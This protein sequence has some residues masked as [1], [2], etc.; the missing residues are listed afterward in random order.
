MRIRKINGIT[1]GDVLAEAIMNDK[2]NVIIP[3][4][5]ALKEEY[6][7]L[8]ESLGIETVMIEDPY[9]DYE[10]TNTII[11]EDR[12]NQYVEHVRDLMERHIYHS[13]TSFHEFEIIAYELMKEVNQVDSARLIDIKERSS[14]LYDHTVMVTILSLVIAKRLQLDKNKRYNIAIG[15]LLHDLGLRY[16]TVPYTNQNM[17]DHDP[18]AEFE[19]KKHTI[20]GY[21]ALEDENWIP[22]VSRK[23]ILNH[24]ENGEGTGFPMRQKCK[25]IECRII[26]TVDAFDCAI[27]GMERERTSVRSALDELVAG[28]GTVFDAKVVDLLS[29]MVAKYPTGTTVVTS[30][31]KEAIV[32]QQTANADKPVVMVLNIEDP[33]DHSLKL[34][35]A[36]SVDISI[37]QVV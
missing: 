3:A 8:F 37:L 12:F 15:C 10:V 17:T 6:I 28:A 9:E 1:T 13:G 7:P 2:K 21:S 16:I 35:L 4:G 20:L 14:D 32:I 11:P 22:K 36:E 29:S 30:E 19:F 18:A 27:S 31:E 24:H 23:M 26:Q 5:I 34:N 33:M 25:E